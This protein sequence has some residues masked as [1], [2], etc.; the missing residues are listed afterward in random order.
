M[1]RRHNNIG[2]LTQAYEDKKNTFE[3]EVL[4]HHPCYTKRYCKPAG[5]RATM[6][7]VRGNN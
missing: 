1:S 4:N 2:P 6:P 7:Y 5:F 3:A